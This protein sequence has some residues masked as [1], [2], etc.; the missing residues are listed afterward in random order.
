[1]WA[2]TEIGIAFNQGRVCSSKNVTLSRSN[3]EIDGRKKFHVFYGVPGTWY[4]CTAGSS[5]GC[6]HVLLFVASPCSA[7]KCIRETRRD[8]M[9]GRLN[10]LSKSSGTTTISKGRISGINHKMSLLGW[11]LIFLAARHGSCACYQ[12]PRTG[13]NRYNNT[14]LNM[15]STT[16]SR[17]RTFFALV[18]RSFLFGVVPKKIRYRSMLQNYGMAR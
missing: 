7:V 14:Y 15:T 10:R 17:W 8:N 12:L 3:L 5:A 1:M 13:T 11:C 18:N 16:V 4:S 6:G 2:G 9:S